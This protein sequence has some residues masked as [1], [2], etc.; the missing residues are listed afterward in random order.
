MSQKKKKKSEIYNQKSRKV[1]FLTRSEKR[2]VAQKGQNIC[3]FGLK[4]YQLKLWQ[5]LVI[6]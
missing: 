3:Y 2:Y 6:V 4:Y 1:F 5:N